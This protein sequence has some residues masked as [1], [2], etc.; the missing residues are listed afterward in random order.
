M[1]WKR[2][3]L[4]RT[5]TLAMELGAC[6]EFFSDPYQLPVITPPQLGLTIVQAERRPVQPGDILAYHVRPFIGLRLDWVTEITHVQPRERFVDE[7]R[8]GPYRMW[9]HLH[10]F[11]SVAGGVRMRDVVDYVLP[12]GVI[13][14]ITHALAVRRK[15]EMIFDYRRDILAER[16]GEPKSIARPMPTGGAGV[17]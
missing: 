9:H 2:Y 4:D 13:G 15:L 1:F 5:Q 17:A 7:Q 3:R 12:L 6:W 16:F 14:R 10:E 8:L 11:E